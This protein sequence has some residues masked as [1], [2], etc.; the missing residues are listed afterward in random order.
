MWF[1]QPMGSDCDAA[2]GSYDVPGGRC[3]CGVRAPEAAVGARGGPTKIFSFTFNIYNIMFWNYF[4]NRIPEW[5]KR[6]I[7][8]GVDRQSGWMATILADPDP[9]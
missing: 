9:A 3:V 1:T 2:L 5:V 4:I 8:E 7:A 6:V